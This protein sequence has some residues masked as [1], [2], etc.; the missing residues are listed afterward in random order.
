MWLELLGPLDWLACSLFLFYS[1]GPELFSSNGKITEQ[2]TF[3][4][5]QNTVYFTTKENKASTKITL[6]ELK[7]TTEIRKRY[8]ERKKHHCGKVYL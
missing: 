7:D 1:R 4:R 8:K 3:I 2:S 5:L 6:I